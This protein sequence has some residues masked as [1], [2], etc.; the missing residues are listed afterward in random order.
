MTQH[1]THLGRWITFVGCSVLSVSSQASGFRLPEISIAGTAMSNAVVANPDLPG[2]LPYN[3]A[4]MA[5]QKQGQLLV[6]TVMI[7]PDISVTSPAGVTTESQGKDNVPVPNIFAATHAGKNWSWGVGVNSPFGLETKWPAG[8]FP[9]FASVAGTVGNPAIAALEPAHSKIEMVNI[10]P[11]VAYQFGN[12]SLALG[13]DVYRVRNLVFNT[14]AIT[15][16]G[17]GQGKGWNVGLLHAHES[18]SV[19]LS[20]RSSVRVELGGTVD[21]TGVGSTASTAGAEIEF[22]SLLQVGARYKVSDSLALEFDV[23]Q[24]GWSSFDVVSIDHSSPGL[25]NPIRSENGWKDAVAY[26]LGGSYELSPTNQLRFGY[27]YDQTPGNDELFS[28]RVPGNDRQTLSLGL[29]HQQ[30]G[31]TI[32]FAY[33][34]V[35]ADDRTISAPANSFLTGVAGGNTDP[36]GTDAYNGTYQLTAHLFGVGVNTQF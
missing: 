27:A 9:T 29:A 3:P 8:T 25:P 24:T 22:P 16:N 7:Q 15:I 1:S 32:E 11:N 18:W 30:A 36:N 19:G 23:E 26:R 35:K 13:L 14:Q 12:T 20:Y 2:A 10:N 28:A 17:S 21:A 5:F 4:A 34:Y 33:M 31:W 6:G